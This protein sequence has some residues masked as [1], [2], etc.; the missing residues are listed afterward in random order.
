M[1]HIIS[2][3]RRLDD[4]LAR[5]CVHSPLA[6]QTRAKP[7][8]LQDSPFGKSATP[9]GDICRSAWS[10]SWERLLKAR[11][12]RTSA[13]AGSASSIRV[14]NTTAGSSSS[15][16][17]VLRNTDFRVSLSIRVVVRSRPRPTPRIDVTRPG[18][19]PPLPKSSHV[20]SFCAKENNWA[21]STIWRSQR[22]SKLD[23]ETRFIRG[24]HF[25]TRLT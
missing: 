5:R 2:L 11:A 17:T 24:D 22:S 9:L 7:S 4:G 3:E 21:E 15:L 10:R 1:Q 16:I 12:E 14:F 8:F 23:L 13:L 20:F 19:P 18:K 25:L 6:C